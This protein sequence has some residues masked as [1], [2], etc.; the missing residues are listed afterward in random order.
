MASPSRVASVYDTGIQET[1]FPVW[2]SRV[3]AALSDFDAL[4]T[5]SMQWGRTEDVQNS[6]NLGLM[7]GDILRDETGQWQARLE[8]P[9]AN[10]GTVAIEHSW[11]LQPE[12]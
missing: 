6:Q 2:E 8:K 11:N 3:E 7:A 4:F 1:G 10:S 12:Q 9:L 5:N